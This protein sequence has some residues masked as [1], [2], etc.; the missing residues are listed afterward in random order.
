[1]ELVSEGGSHRGWNPDHHEY[2]GHQ[3]APAYPHQ[4]GEKTN[5]GPHPISRNRLMLIPATGRKTCIVSVLSHLQGVTARGRTPSGLDRR[6]QFLEVD[7]GDPGHGGSY[8]LD[9]VDLVKGPKS[10]PGWRP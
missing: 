3:K 1:M 7:R 5:D 10:S 9:F 4:P 2:R 8:A 6:R